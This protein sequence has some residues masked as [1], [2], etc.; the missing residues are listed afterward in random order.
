[1]LQVYHFF[2]SSRSSVDRVSSVRRS[3]L[4][5]Y[6]LARDRLQNSKAP[7]QSVKP[8][9][10]IRRPDGSIDRPA[11]VLLI[12]RAPDPSQ[13]RQKTLIHHLGVRGGRRRLL[14]RFVRPRHLFIWT[15]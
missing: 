8:E 11:L 4:Y 6:W 15:F 7:I 5:L 14:P 9:Q 2:A 13:R 1:M 3:V 12:S 10:T